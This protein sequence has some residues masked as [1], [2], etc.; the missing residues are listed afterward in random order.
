[1]LIASSMA[2][3]FN[4]VVGVVIGTIS[5]SALFNALTLLGVPPGTWQEVVLGMLVIAVTIVSMRGEEGVVK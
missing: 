5:L 3:I 4:V 1:V 2:A